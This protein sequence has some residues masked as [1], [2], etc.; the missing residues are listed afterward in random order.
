LD[1]RQDRQCK[2]QPFEKGETMKSVA[3]MGHGKAMV[4]GRTLRA[5]AL[6]VVCAMML[7]A[8]GCANMGETKT[9]AKLRRNRVLRL[10]LQEMGEDINVA[11]M[12]DRPNRLTDKRLP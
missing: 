6:A 5:L 1:K 8:T 10:D 3:T 4:T 12:L 7:L 9:E 2:R 11:L